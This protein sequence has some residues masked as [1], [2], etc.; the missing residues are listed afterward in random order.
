MPLCL[1]R[2]ASP[3]SDC[4]PSNARRLKLNLEQL[5]PS[6]RNVCQ[7]QYLQNI[8]TQRLPVSEYLEREVTLPKH[9]QWPLQHQ[10]QQQTVSTPRLTRKPTSTSAPNTTSPSLNHSSLS[11]LSK[12]VL[13]IITNLLRIIIIHSGS[14]PSPLSPHSTRIAL[15]T[16][17][18][19]S[20]E[21]ELEPN[22]FSK[23]G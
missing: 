18:Y 4:Y 3:S 7:P 6:Q 19:K 23:Q 5:P 8:P 13:D 14:F 22:S 12:T 21:L 20:H 17:H 16:P 11:T 9:L 1:F 15:F 2:R 10:F